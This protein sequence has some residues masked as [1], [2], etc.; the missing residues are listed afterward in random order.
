MQTLGQA[1]PPAPPG[2][3]W[4][5]TP[6]GPGLAPIPVQAPPAT[7]TAQAVPP[8]RTA[9]PSAPI[10]QE[11][12]LG[13]AILVIAFCESSTELIAL[14]LSLECVRAGAPIAPEVAATLPPEIRAQMERSLADPRW[15][16]AARKVLAD[17]LVNMVA[18]GFLRT[19]F[20]IVPSAR[21]DDP[22]SDP[23]WGVAIQ[24]AYAENE[25]RIGDM[26]DGVLECLDLLPEESS[27]PVAAATLQAARPAPPQNTATTPQT[28]QPAPPQN[29]AATP[30]AAQPAPPQNT[31]TTPKAPTATA[32]EIACVVAFVLVFVGAWSKTP[33]FIRLSAAV[34]AVAQSKAPQPDPARVAEGYAVLRDPVLV[35]ACVALF[36]R[37]RALWRSKAVPAT[38]EGF[39]RAVDSDGVLNAVLKMVIDRAARLAAPAPV[40]ASP[41]PT[42]APKAPEAPVAPVAVAPAPT[43]PKAPEATPAAPVVRLAIRWPPDSRPAVLAPPVYAARVPEP[44][45]VAPA[46]VA[47]L[48]KAPRRVP[49]AA[50]PW[51]SAR[52][53]KRPRIEPPPPPP[54]ASSP[55]PVVR[56]RGRPRASAGATAP[57][58]AAP[59][60][61]PPAPGPAPFVKDELRR[62]RAPPV[63]G[64]ASFVTDELRARAPAQPE[65]C[66]QIDE[67]PRARAPPTVPPR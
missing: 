34:Y 58:R 37:T 65:R 7:P 5:N 4:V 42:S 12:A 3:Q 13:T 60:P 52:A 47:A 64:R 51:R 53:R 61:T 25:R 54:A 1:L 15:C 67:P 46:S 27:A 14:A 11:G 57:V 26:A 20:A 66:N 19:C 29:T 56:T 2:F 30:Q 21:P 22:L 28:A 49:L 50:A 62:V 8:L 35:A 18:R 24:K 59:V 38:W 16:A 10:A 44:P 63:A 40:A 36:G 48:S 9:Q 45:D 6:H 41:L 23:A 33:A 31:A 39:S 55:A 17:S 32:E 43:T